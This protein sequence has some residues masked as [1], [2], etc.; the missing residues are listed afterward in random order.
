MMFYFLYICMDG[1][2]NI[3]E[4]IGSEEYNELSKEAQKRI[5]YFHQGYSRD[6][7]AFKTIL[8]VYEAF[9]Y[10]SEILHREMP[11]YQV[12]SFMEKNITPV[13]DFIVKELIANRE[14]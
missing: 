9:V 8:D 5:S 2:K 4:Y 10:L 14:I 12:N 11:V 1:T 13:R 7:R 6:K 3:A